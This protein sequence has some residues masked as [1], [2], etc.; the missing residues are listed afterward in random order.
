MRSLAVICR[1]GHQSFFDV[2]GRDPR[3]APMTVVER[4]V[5]A[6]CL[7]ELWEAEV[8]PGDELGVPRGED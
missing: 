8:K 2:T 3:V 6:R 5:F 1:Y 4:A 7:V